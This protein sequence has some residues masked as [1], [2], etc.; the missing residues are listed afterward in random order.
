MGVELVLNTAFIIAKT[1]NLYYL[2]G[3]NKWYSSKSVS[4]PWKFE[5]SIPK[6]LNKLNSAIRENEKKEDKAALDSAAKITPEIIV[7]TEPAELI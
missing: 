5:K 3:S 2:Y 7:R 1:G 4:G 6:S